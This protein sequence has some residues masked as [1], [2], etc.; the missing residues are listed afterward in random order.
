MAIRGNISLSDAAST[1]VVHVFYPTEKAGN[2]I[3]WKDRTQGIAAGQ[4]TLS[5]SQRPSSKQA[6]TYKMLWRLD[7]PTLEQSSPSTGSGYQPAPKV[8]Y[9]NTFEMTFVMH[10]RA[11]LQERK[12]LLAM[13]RDLID[14]AI[15]AAEVQD[16]DLIW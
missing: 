1:P 2:I 5:V 9:T 15:I 13:A 16:L 10:E 14:E 11:T 3:F 7:V 6:P 8:A 4:P 12:D